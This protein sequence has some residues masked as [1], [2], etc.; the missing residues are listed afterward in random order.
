MHEY[1]TMM[2]EIQDI[3]MLQTTLDDFVSKKKSR[4]GKHRHFRDY[5]RK[6]HGALVRTYLHQASRLDSF[7]P[8][9]SPKATPARRVSIRNINGIVR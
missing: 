6:R 7:W 3:E 9:H 8:P 5:L 4:L 2:G 1:Q